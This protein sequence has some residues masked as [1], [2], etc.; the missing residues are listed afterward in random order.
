MIK[1]EPLVEQSQE[2]I[3]NA[4]KSVVL[5]SILVVIYNQ[6][7]EIKNIYSD[8]KNTFDKR[9]P[10]HYEI[11]FVDD[12]STD[13]SDRLLEKIKDENS[14]VKIVRM[15]SNFGEA[16][17]LE[18]GLQISSGDI[19]VYSTSR[20]RIDPKGFVNLIDKIKM[21]YDLVIGWR[22]PRQDWKLNRIVSKS[23]NNA[24]ARLTG[25]KLHDI[26][27]GVFVAKRNVIESLDLYGDLN[28]FIPILVYKLGYKITEEKIPQKRGTFRKSKYI[29]EYFQRILDILTIIF[30]TKYSKKPLHFLGLFGIFF[31]L[32]GGAID[33]Y[34]FV[35]RIFGFGPIAGRPL[36]LLGALLFILGI[37]MISIGLIGEMIIFTHA[38]EIKEYSIENI[39]E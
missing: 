19:L 27:S 8:F 22:Y 33:L 39:C 21:G 1:T 7:K 2:K 26:N 35:Y 17:A 29:T 4:P 9:F 12:G 34:L 20:V 36:L 25:L 13:G 28:N 31:T 32:V 16:S 37:Q 38:S 23:F 10:G 18:A 11:I 15:R 24:V 3:E 6:V 5:I 14:N 30:L